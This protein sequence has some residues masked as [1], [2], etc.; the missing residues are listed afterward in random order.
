MAISR[1]SSC[2]ASAARASARSSP[3]RSRSRWGSTSGSGCR[4][5]KSRRVA[6][7]RAVTTAAA[8]DGGDHGAVHGPRQPGGPRAVA[9]RRARRERGNMIFNT[10][11]MHAAEIPAANGITNAASLSRMYAACVVRG[12]RHPPADPRDRRQGERD[13]DERARPGAH[14]RV[15]VRPRLHDARDHDAD[16]RPVVVRPRGCRRLR[17]LRRRRQRCLVR[18]R[19][20]PDA[21]EPRGRS[22]PRRSHRRGEGE[23]R[24]APT[25]LNRSITF[26]ASAT[27]S[28]DEL[29]GGTEL[30]DRTDALAGTG[31]TRGRGRPSCARRRRGG[32][33]RLASRRA[34]AAGTA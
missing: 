5:R 4:R 17:R 29:G 1:A 10:P 13:A 20:E 3:T 25:A 11:A 19:H 7:A 31:R 27:N 12:R 32:S 21:D 22:A 9:R 23:P 16:A 26:S 28:C 24:L 15:D 33:R 14:A 6:A 2:A 34:P 8:R 30:V 18:L